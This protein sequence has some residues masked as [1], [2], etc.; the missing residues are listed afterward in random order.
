MLLLLLAI[1]ASA[2]CGQTILNEDVF[3][4]MLLA[5]HFEMFV[6]ALAERGSSTNGS[7]HDGNHGLNSAVNRSIW[8]KITLGMPLPGSRRRYAE[9]HD[10]SR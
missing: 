9:A 7:I 5:E 8:C 2:A 3:V 6:V 1:L 10:G 4:S